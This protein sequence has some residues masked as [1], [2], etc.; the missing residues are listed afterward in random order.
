[1][2]AHN[3]NF[4]FLA[5]DEEVLAGDDIRVV[6]YAFDLFFFLLLLLLPL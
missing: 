6:L 2:A 4:P 3:L 1:M 5:K